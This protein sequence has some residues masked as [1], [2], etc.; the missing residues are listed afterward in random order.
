MDAKILLERLQPTT[1]SKFQQ[2]VVPKPKKSKNCSRKLESARVRRFCAAEL[3]SL[4]VPRYPM[5]A[6]V[7]HMQCD[8]GFDSLRAG[9]RETSWHR[10]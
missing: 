4:F 3:S 10:G 2:F 7:S 5:V 8:C 6:D 9:A 1:G